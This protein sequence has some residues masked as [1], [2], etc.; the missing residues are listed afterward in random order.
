M[1]W[2]YA[3]PGCDTYAQPTCWLKG[4]FPQ[5]TAQS[6]RISGA[7]A[8]GPSASAISLAASLVYNLGN[9]NNVA[10]SRFLTLAV[11]EVLSIDFFGESCPPYWRRTLPINDS[12]VIPTDMLATA[13]V[14]YEAV[15]TQCDQFDAKTALMLSNVGGDEYATISQLVYRQALGGGSSLVWMP[16]KLSAY[17]FVKEISSCGCLQ[18]SDVIYPF[19][20]ILLYYSPEM[21]K[22]ML[23]PHLEYAMNY[24]NQPYPLAW[25]PHHLGY[26]PIADLPY[27]GQENMPLEETAYF[28]LQIAAIAQRQGGDVTWLEPYWPAIQ[29]WYAFLAGL[30]PFPQEQLSTDDVCIDLCIYIYT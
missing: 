20:P 10:V 11:D 27:T 14:T 30:L 5:P 28:M 13:F 4:A 17:Y 1:A 29:N 12:S 23:L 7:Q 3:I 24:T 9:V 6:C 21:S 26:W 15:R 18:T 16:S 22:L 8:G 19:F 2:A 25:A